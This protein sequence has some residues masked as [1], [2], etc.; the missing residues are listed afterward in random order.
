MGPGKAALLEKVGECRS[1]AGAG[2]ALGLSYWKTRHLIDE[3]NACF[4]APVVETTKGGNRR[5]GAELTAMG[6]IA[7]DRFR[8]LEAQARQAVEAGFA[9][10]VELL[11]D[12]P[13]ALPGVS[14]EA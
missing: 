10:Y 13:D 7:L 3:M 14:P 2:R 12:R 5:G 11:K 6:R 4:Q 1:I 9:A 8:V